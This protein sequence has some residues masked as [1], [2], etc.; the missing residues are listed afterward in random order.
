MKR[1]RWRKILTFVALQ[2]L[3]SMALIA[4]TFWIAYSR[5]QCARVNPDGT[6]DTF[7]GEVCRQK[8]RGN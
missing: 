8:W 6:M 4:A 2:G 1:V 5:P 3:Y 7:I